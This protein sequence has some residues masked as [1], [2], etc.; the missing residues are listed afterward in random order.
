MSDKSDNPGGKPDANAA[1]PT[2]LTIGLNEPVKV[3]GVTYTN[4]T[5]RRRK[6]KDLA[7]M[8][9][10]KGNTRKSFAMYASMA[11]VPLPVMEELDGDD[12]DRIVEETVPLMGKSMQKA[13]KLEMAKRDLKAQ[14]QAMEEADEADLQ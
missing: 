12:Y 8:D 10:V 3:G 7:A 14:Q 4:L 13:I 1:A 6:A 11:G 5:F 9:L 2:S